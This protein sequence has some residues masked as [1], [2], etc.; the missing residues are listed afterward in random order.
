MI[1]QLSQLHQV[2]DTD[3]GAPLTQDDLRIRDNEVSP[4]SRNGPDLHV[5]DP[6]QDPRAGSVAPLADADELTSVERVER[7]RHPHKVRRSEGNACIPR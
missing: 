2:P 4:R 7:M 5:V 6:Q 1:N 3:A